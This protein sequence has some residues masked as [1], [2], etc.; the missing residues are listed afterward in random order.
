MQNHPLARPS[1]HPED[2]TPP[3]E[4]DGA[5]ER[6]EGRRKK[7][8]GTKHVS[9]CLP[10]I[11]DLRNGTSYAAW[12]VWSGSTTKEVK[13][14]PLPRKVAVR[15]YHKAVRWNA[16]AKIA[17]RHGGVLGMPA[18]EV[19]HTMIFGFLN[20]KTGR[21]DPGYDAIQRKTRLCRQTVARALERLKSLGILNWQRRCR[22][23]K[24]QH[25]RFMLMQQTNAYGVLPPSQWHGF[26][27]I[28][29]EPPH[30]STWGAM[31]PL[32]PLIEQAVMD[33]RDG[34]SMRSVLSRL[35]ADPGDELACQMASL[36]QSVHAR[37]IP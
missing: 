8:F 11:A 23:G 31:P 9:A 14:V 36:F 33:T 26:I 1:T 6:L 12:H 35:D 19:L 27:D 30:A 22:P 10:F 15:M 7:S 5:L 28:E 25:G 2:G 4:K 13:F 32:P 18:L 37:E 29:P 16:Q 24:D 20:Y 3:F 21:L 34:D 17:G